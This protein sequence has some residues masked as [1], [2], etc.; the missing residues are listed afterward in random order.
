MRCTVQSRDNPV[1]YR[2]SPDSVLKN[3]D[4]SAA[5][6]WELFMK[7]DTLRNR[8]LGVFRIKWS[9]QVVRTRKYVYHFS[10]GMWLLH[11]RQ[12][13]FQV[14]APR[15]SRPKS[16]R[17]LSGGCSPGSLDY[18]MKSG[19]AIGGN[20]FFSVSGANMN[21]WGIQNEAIGNNTSTNNHRNP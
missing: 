10:Q 19:Y 6:C 14:E 21:I 12:V 2:T 18:G 9:E 3:C 16:L 15:R 4:S 17:S 8:C 5:A 7:F 11:S 13:Q 20:I 1:S